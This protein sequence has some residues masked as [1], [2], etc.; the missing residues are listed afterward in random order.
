MLKL[1]TE[2]LIVELTEQELETISG[3]QADFKGNSGNLF[4]PSGKKIRTGQT[5][6][7]ADKGPFGGGN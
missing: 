7:N 6:G 5:N 2:K 4:T 3:G 1:K